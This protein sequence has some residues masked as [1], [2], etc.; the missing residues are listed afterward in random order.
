MLS[1]D[2]RTA[3]APVVAKIDHVGVLADDADTLF[4]LFAETF[5]LPVVW[6]MTDYG[7]FASGGVRVGNLDLE[8]LRAAGGVR[9]FVLPDRPARY[10]ILGWRPT[11]S[12]ANSVARLAARGIPFREETPGPFYTN[13]TLT[14]L[15][16]GSWVFLC[17]YQPEWY[18]RYPALAEQFQERRGGPLGVADAAEVTVGVRE[19]AQAE[20]RWGRLLAP[21]MPERPG[22]WQV[23]DGP[24]VRLESDDRDAISTLTL[25]V[26][27]LE[28]AAR[29]LREQGLLGDVSAERVLL[30]PDR[31]GSLR[32]NLVTVGG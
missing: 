23:G 11:G 26:R 19:F 8:F 21:T 13:V 28:Q 1:S 7:G 18:H 25:Q 10:W 12:V 2:L 30:A 17:H 9:R 24:A 4:T 14:D 5:Q 16:P 32:L 29:F 22:T 15:S 6:P 31:L 3:S 27:D 20:Q